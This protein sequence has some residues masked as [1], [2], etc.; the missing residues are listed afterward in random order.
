MTDEK[1]LDREMELAQQVLDSQIA[2]TASR[3]RKRPTG[4]CLYC[5]EVIDKELSFCPPEVPGLPGCR[6]DYEAEEA[7]L[8]RNGRHRRG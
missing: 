7:A 1:I 6:D 2:E 5:N 8:R 3:A 4:R